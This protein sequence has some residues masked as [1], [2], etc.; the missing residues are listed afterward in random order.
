[1]RLKLYYKDPARMKLLELTSW[2]PTHRNEMYWSM[3]KTVKHKTEDHTREH[4]GP[5]TYHTQRMMNVYQRILP[6]IDL[7]SSSEIIIF[8]KS[9]SFI[10]MS[11]LKILWCWFIGYC[12]FP[13]VVFQNESMLHEN[14]FE[15]QILAITASLRSVN[16]LSHWSGTKSMFKISKCNVLKLYR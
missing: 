9:Q 16:V 3:R 7:P 4:T 5:V 11:L 15:M 8:N 13:Y 6:G 10:S 1:M 12:L 2:R 14:R